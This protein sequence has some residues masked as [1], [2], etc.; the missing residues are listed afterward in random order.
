LDDGGA[1]K[2]LQEFGTWAKKWQVEY[3]EIFCVRTSVN[4]RARDANI[5][6]QPKYAHLSKTFILTSG[7]FM[8]NFQSS[9]AEY[10][11]FF[12]LSNICN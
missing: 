12:Q 10:G 9:K 1:K 5:N 2:K 4:Y 6:P 11:M 3:R 7:V 8:S